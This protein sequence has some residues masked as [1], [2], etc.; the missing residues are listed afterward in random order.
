M[1]HD[2]ST[3]DQWRYVHSKRNPSDAASR[4]LSAKALLESHSWK[5]GP[6]FLWQGESSWPTPPARQENIIDDDLEIKIEVR[7]HAIDLDMSM[8]TI[9]KLLCYFSSWVNLI[10]SMASLL[11]FKLWLLNKVR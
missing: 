3:P 8:D 10:K 5:G 11:R 2:G 9:E 6:D 1:I 4:R 7:V